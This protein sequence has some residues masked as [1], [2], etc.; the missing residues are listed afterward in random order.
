MWGLPLLFLLVLIGLVLI[1]NPFCS[2]STEW[3]FDEME[4]VVKDLSDMRPASLRECGG[5]FMPD[6]SK[7]IQDLGQE[8]YEEVKEKSKDCDDKEILL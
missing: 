4:C 3:S 7:Q 5:W 1:A 6:T 8:Y 2:A